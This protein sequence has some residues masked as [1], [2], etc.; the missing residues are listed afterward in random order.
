MATMLADI[1]KMVDS[2]KI[3]LRILTQLFLYNII[4]MIHEHPQTQ[5]FKMATILVIIYKIISS[6]SPMQRQLG[7]FVGNP[8][9]SL[10]ECPSPMQ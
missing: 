10:S 1:F 3:N 7:N 8:P 9:G 5:F 4:L 2:L 6:V